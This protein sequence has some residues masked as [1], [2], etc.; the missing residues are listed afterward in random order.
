MFEAIDNLVNQI[1]YSGVKNVVIC[2]GSRN[3]PL[4]ISF[5][6][7]GLFAIECI[8]DE[9]S[10]GFIAMGMA[11]RSQS[12]VALLCTSG[13]ALTNFYPA[14]VEA[15]YQRIPLLVISA[16]RPAAL[17][18]QW[19]GQTIRQFGLFGQHV[20][21][22][23][24]TSEDYSD[25]ASFGQVAFDALALALNELKGPVHINVPLQEPLYPAPD[26]KFSPSLVPL[27]LQETMVK[28]STELPNLKGKKVFVLRGFHLREPKEAAAYPAQFCDLM[29]GLKGASVP[30]Q[31]FMVADQ[32]LK[33]ALQAEVLLS[34]G[35]AVLPK[36]LKNYLR[37]YG[38]QE[39]YH[40]SWE[41]DLADPFFSHPKLIRG[42][43]DRFIETHT[44]EW[45]ANF[46][47]RWRQASEQVRTL[48][49]KFWETR[50]FTEFTAARQFL[51]EIENNAVL[52]V[53]NSMPV[54]FASLI[55]HSGHRTFCNRGTSG[56]DGCVSTALGMTYQ[57]N[58]P[59]FLLVGDVAFF[60]DSNA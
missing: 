60:Y 35:T 55:R 17:I 24:S 58:S 8:P 26:R 30:E 36:A 51:Q 16:D 3:A 37:N 43:L 25:T 29:S 20:K 14:V 50:P 5:S 46:A 41:G 54:R 42:D 22:S 34:D 6:R 59:Q 1:H 32:D 13:S 12:P 23:F 56:I 39:H 19:D 27:V 57:S 38:P 45:D 48:E 2:P 4:S 47:E 33:M 49:S 15:F 21:G 52:H 9:R 31:L 44:Q 7:S 11:I 53:A 10:A 28:K 40:F 18:D